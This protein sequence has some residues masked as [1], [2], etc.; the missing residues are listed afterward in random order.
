MGVSPFT[1]RWDSPAQKKFWKDVDKA[2]LALI[3]KHKKKL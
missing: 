2:I 3:Q 1:L